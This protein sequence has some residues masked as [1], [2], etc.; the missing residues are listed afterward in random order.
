VKTYYP[1]YFQ[2]AMDTAK[3]IE[4]YYGRDKEKFYAEFG[5]DLGQEE[6][7]EYCKF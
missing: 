2:E 6:T 7:C 4:G 5:R 3:I 1:V